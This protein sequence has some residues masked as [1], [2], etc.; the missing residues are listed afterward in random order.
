ML[1]RLHTPAY[2]LERLGPEEARR[3]LAQI[4]F[5]P[6]PLPAQADELVDALGGVVLALALLGATIAHGTSWATALAE[7]RAAGDVYTDEGFANQFRALQLAWGAL[8]DQQRQR[9]AELVVFGEDVIA[10]PT[11]V[12]RLWSHTA[13]LDAEA[14]ERLCMALAERN[15][16]AYDG[17]VRLH[18]LQRA[19]LLLQVP[20]SALAHRQLLTAY[21][22]A[23]ATPGRWSSL[24]DDERY[25]PDHLVEHLVA[26]GDVS[27]LQEV[28][29]DPVWL[30]R[31]FHHNGPH[32]PESDLE[33]A[34]AALPTFRAGVQALDRW[35]LISHALGGSRRSA[36]AR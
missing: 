18:D 2:P 7:V 14:S 26:A 3:F 10:P 11:T 19:F 8:D 17:G 6:G 35:R 22:D 30:L 23:Q 13:G 1:A 9:Y 16:L 32:A 20:D 4:A 12:A 28:V 21:E 36:T 15:L 25:L 5:H 34:L 33:Q 27:G 29:T 31:R 24:P